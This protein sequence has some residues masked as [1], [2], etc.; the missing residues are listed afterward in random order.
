MIDWQRNDLLIESVICIEISH[1]FFMQLKFPFNFLLCVANSVQKPSHRLKGRQLFLSKFCTTLFKS[2]N[3]D[4]IPDKVVLIAQELL[5]NEWMNEWLN[6]INV[7]YY[8]FYFMWV[9]TGKD[10]KQTKLKTES[11][12]AQQLCIRKQC[13]T[14]CATAL[15]ED[16]R[17]ALGS[18]IVFLC[19]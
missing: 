5:S 7:F 9:R 4:Y 1:F 11:P 15:T 12:R 2:K 10:L 3:T 18:E 14:L 8:L 19:L 6:T 13:S 16:H 17:N